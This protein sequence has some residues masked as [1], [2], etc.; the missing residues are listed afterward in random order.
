MNRKKII[1]YFVCILL[2]LSFNISKVFAEESEKDVLGEPIY[3]EENE[4][5]ITE[6]INESETNT[7]TI[8]NDQIKHTKEEITKKYLNSKSTVGLDTIK[9]L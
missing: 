2:I 8:E 3:L 6:S 1:I 5:H 4:V 9:H 7:S